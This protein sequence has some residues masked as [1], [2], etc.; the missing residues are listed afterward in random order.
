VP[1][2]AKVR[3]DIGGSDHCERRWSSAFGTTFVP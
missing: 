2:T 3:L 1:A